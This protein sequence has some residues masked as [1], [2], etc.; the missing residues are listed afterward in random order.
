M[1]EIESENKNSYAIEIS[2]ELQAKVKKY[3]KDWY[4]FYKNISKEKTP[5]VDGN[6]K[7]IIGKKGN[8]DYI[9][10]GYMVICLD[11]YFP[12]WSWEMAA[13]IQF[14]GTEWVV[15]QGILSII[16]EKLLAFK[17]NPPYRK[18]YGVNAKAITYRRETKHTIENIVDVGNDV[19]IANT[20]AFKVALNRLTHIGDDIYGKRFEEEG[21]GSL[22]DIAIEK[23]DL[24]SF[25]RWMSDNGIKNNDAREILK[26]GSLTEIIDFKDAMGKILKAKGII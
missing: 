19:K 26:V 11:K 22:E 16:D 3:K 21:A 1:T 2:D 17:I 4:N 14:L 7:K 24:S 9:D 20:E 18:F 15:A 25:T 5:Q 6:G 10:V 12:G 8:F 23:N 13:P